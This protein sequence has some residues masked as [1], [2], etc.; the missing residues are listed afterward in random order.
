M[1]YPGK[2]AGL[3]FILHLNNVIFLPYNELISTRFLCF[4]AC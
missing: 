4:Y 1:E 3:N 2:F